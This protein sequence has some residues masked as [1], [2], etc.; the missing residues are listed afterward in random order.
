MKWIVFAFAMFASAVCLADES[1]YTDQLNNGW[2]NWSWASVNLSSTAYAHSGK[3]SIAVTETGANQALYLSTGDQPTGS[4]EGIQFWINGGATGGQTLQVQGLLDGNSG[5]AYSLPPLQANT[6]Q[7]VIVPLVGVGTG[8]VGNFT[9]FWIQDTSNAAGPAWYVDDV[10]LISMPKVTPNLPIYTDSMQSGWTKG[11]TATINLA[12]KA[13]NHSGKSSIA[14]TAT[15]AS[16]SISFSHAPV[17]GSIYRALTFWIDGGPK[18]GQDLQVNAT[19]GGISQTT[20]NLP[21]LAKNVWQEVTIP[22]QALGVDARGDLDSFE[23]K[24]RSGIVQPTYYLDDIT[25][26]SSPAVNPLVTITVNTAGTTPISPY[27]YGINSTDFANMGPGFTLCRQGGNRLT[28]YNWENN[29]S[30]AGSDYYFQN[31]DLMGATD[32]A[33]WAPLTFLQAATS[34][35]AV[36]LLTIPMVDYVA[37]DK[38]GGGDI[39]NTT[40]YIHVRLRQNLPVK[41]GGNYVYPPDTSDYY[42]YED[43]FVNYIKGFATPKYPIFFCLDNEPDLWASTHAEVH[44]IPVTYAEM[45]QRT[46]SF[47]TQVKKVYPGATLFGPVSYGWYGYRTLQGA[48]DANGRDFL[49]YFLQSMASADKTAG[50]RLLDVLDLHWYPEATGDNIRIVSEGDSDGLAAARIQAS[51]SLWDATYV[52]DS[53]ITGSLGG[54][55]I[56]LIPGTMGLIANNYPGTKLSFSEYNYGGG[57]SISG[58]IA[59]ADVL[60]VFGRYGV[61][62]AANWGIGYTEAAEV[63][64]FQSFVNYDRKG[65]KFGDMELAV[66][67]EKPAANSV[68]AALDS[69]NPKRMTL[70]VI[71]KTFESTPFNIDISKFSVLSS[72]AYQVTAGNYT[73]PLSVP[74]TNLLDGVSFT[75]PP[76]SITTIELKSR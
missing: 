4:Y 63:A 60:G 42:V 6:W 75:A 65:A 62:A 45:I 1:I 74:V 73:T 55:G 7:K 49:T 43:E 58:A 71:N 67:G 47:A 50:K 70:V 16:E 76:Y 51:R 25:L 15:K 27:I 39:R 28:A 57:N 54:A 72:K 46:T 2:Q 26:T 48:T 64:G 69:T 68:Y 52:E 18:G 40:D 36:P 3:Y 13:P 5:I 56:N 61:Y 35:G 29:A 17:D 12:N 8:S 22:L 19:A 20:F 34:G 23:I 53:W 31:D 24:D 41:A 21:P 38:L 59:Q 44:P 33:G 37:A 9:G 66:K 10:S 30:N 32:Q 11:G 14:V